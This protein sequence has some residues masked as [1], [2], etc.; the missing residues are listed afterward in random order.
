MKF[1]RR[2]LTGAMSFSFTMSPLLA[3]FHIE[4]E[5]T[6]TLL[7]TQCAAVRTCRSPIRLPPQA[8]LHPS[9]VQNPA[10]T[11]QGQA[12]D[13]ALSKRERGESWVPLLV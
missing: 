12:P 3:F 9:A 4:V 5:W 6:H 1:L 13:W 11:I 2:K 10:E 7:S 8:W